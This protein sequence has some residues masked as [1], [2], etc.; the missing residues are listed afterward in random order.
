MELKKELKILGWIIALFLAAFFLPTDS[1]R[2]QEAIMATLDLS[3]WYAREH[4]VLCLLPAFFIAGV[5]AVF[6]SQGA[7]MKY[8]GAKAKKWVAYTVASVSGTILAV[9]SCTILPLFSSIH[10][11]G[12]GL[13]PAIAFLYSGPAINILAIILTARILGIE[14]GVAR[15]IGAVSFAIVIGSIMSL[16]YRKEEKAKKEEQMNF[17]DIPEERPMW[18]TAFHFFTLV[19][20]LV[21][22]NWGKPGDDVTSGGWY[23]LW[24]NKWYITSFF[25]IL[26][27]FSLIFILKL[28]WQ[29]VLVGA[30]ITAASAFTTTSPLVPM[31]VGIAALSL[32][33]LTDKQD[34]NREWTL[35]T[36]DFA[37]QIMP[38]LALG[39]VVAGFLLGSTHDDTAMAGIIPNQWISSL[40][41]G[42]SL[43]SNF[44]ASIVG[45]FMYFATLTEVPILQG[46]MAAGMGK[47]PALALL[48]AGPSLSLPNMLVIRGVMGTRKTITYV[49]LVVVMA[50]ISGLIFGALF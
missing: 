6:I 34:V 36:W 25:S 16:I 7:V 44:F 49:A 22:A 12:A 17:P 40:V 32:I 24:A 45:A 8:F 39:V 13:G 21:F 5:I 18:Q 9:C 3:K 4:V 15:I 26:L 31:V 19:L 20:I 23:W 38:L 46:L 28:P 41:G 48:L 11:R 10:K 29:K 37:K 14:I 35:S 30:I 42:N 1:S 2:F 33:T 50:T 47:G 27:L 43:F